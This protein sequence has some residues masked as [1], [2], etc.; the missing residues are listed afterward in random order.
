[1]FVNVYELKVL[2]IHAIQNYS[3]RFGS[4][5]CVFKNQKS[6]G[7]YLEAINNASEKTYNTMYTMACTVVLFLTILGTEYSKNSKC[8]RNEKIITHKVYKGKGKVMSLFKT[9]LTLFHRA[10]NSKKYIRLPI[11][12]VLYDM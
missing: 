6:N 2:S 10:I 7:L 3:H 9:G 4:I 8:Y 12:F 5:E 1:M 11:R